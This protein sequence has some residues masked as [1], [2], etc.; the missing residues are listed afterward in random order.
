MLDSVF[1]PGGGR[2]VSVDESILKVVETI[3]AAST[4]ESLWPQVMR[5]LLGITDSIAATFCVIDGS[6]G[7]RFPAFVTLNFE[8]KF[9]DE[10]LAGMVVHDPT[11]QFI[12]A[13]PARKLIH[14]SEFITEREKDKLSYYDWHHSF[15]DTRHR[16]AAMASLAPTIQ[17]G[18]TLHR[19]KGQGDFEAGHIERFRFLIPHL[20]RAVRVG[21]QLGTFGA[22]QQ[23]SCQMMDKSPLGIVVLDDRGRILFANEA[24]RTIAAAG[25]GLTI[26]ED[27]IALQHPWHDK[28]L[29]RLLGNVLAR[30]DEPT[31]ERDGVM[32][33]LRPSGKRP[34]SI[35]VSRLSPTAFALT[36]VRPAACA[37]IVD[38]EA[39]MRLSESVLRRLYGLTRSEARLAESLANGDTLQWAAAEFGISYPTARTQLAAIFRKT[40]TSRQSELV[41]LLLSDARLGA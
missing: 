22:M 2:A 40:G 10:Y 21:F 17:S 34:Y 24:A 33:A 9:M 25:D 7:P 35:L 30:L 20:E 29:Q 26:G 38:P 32:Q 18:I 4:D 5:E 41:K 6:D 16:L 14:D 12:V 31:A 36:G 19:T 23:L 13:H 15:S 8:Q 39:P 3:Y 11:V 27:G 28:T 1:V 37:A